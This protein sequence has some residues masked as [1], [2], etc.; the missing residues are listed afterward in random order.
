MRFDLGYF[1]SV[2]ILKCSSEAIFMLSKKIF[3]DSYMTEQ[4]DRILTY[5]IGLTDIIILYFLYFY[6]DSNTNSIS[7][8]GYDTNGCRYHKYV[9]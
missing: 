8:I 7:Y 2:F 4:T 3:I 5:I 6:S 1:R 9:I